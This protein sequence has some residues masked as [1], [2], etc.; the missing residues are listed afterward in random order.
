MGRMIRVGAQSYRFFI[1]L[2]A[3]QTEAELAL[4]ERLGQSDERMKSQLLP[5]RVFEWM[6]MEAGEIRECHVGLPL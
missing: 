1:V 6:N 3:N 5:S 4:R 2:I